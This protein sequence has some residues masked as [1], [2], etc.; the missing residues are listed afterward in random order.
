MQAFRRDVKGGLKPLTGTGAC[1]SDTGN[2]PLGLG[3]CVTGRGL[4]DVERAVLSANQK[5]IY[6]NA[7]AIRRRSRC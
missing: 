1:V 6:T 7:Y 3:T 4:F 2:S 5:Y